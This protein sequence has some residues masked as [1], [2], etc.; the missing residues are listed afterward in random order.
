MKKRTL[1]R[2]LAAFLA[3]MLMAQSLCLT[4]FAEETTLETTPE[5]VTETEPSTRL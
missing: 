3:V 4:A 2:L 5:A 1:S